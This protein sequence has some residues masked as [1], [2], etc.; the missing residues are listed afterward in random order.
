MLLITEPSLQMLFDNAV[1]GTWNKGSQVCQVNVL[2]L[3][4]T[5][6]S[7]PQAPDLRLGGGLLF[8]SWLLYDFQVTLLLHFKVSLEAVGE[9]IRK[10]QGCSSAFAAYKPNSV[11]GFLSN[12]A[13]VLLLL[14]WG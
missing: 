6:S 10:E 4:Y 3:G 5:S 1:G 11:P 7:T 2:P 12:V 13:P 14:G 9:W 8:L